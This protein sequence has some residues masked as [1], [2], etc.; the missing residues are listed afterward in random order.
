MG[1]ILV[2][3]SGYSY[4][5][6]V[7]P[8]YTQGTK[9]EEFLSHYGRLFP[10]VELNFSYYRMPTSDQLLAMVE[11]APSLKFSL[12]A[13]GSM[14]HTIDPIQWRS[15]AAE[16]RK[17]ASALQ[18]A[19]ALAA[20][21]LQFPSSFYYQRQQRTYLHQIVQTLGEFPVAVEFRNSQWYNTR[22][23]D[24]LRQRQ[25]AL[26]CTDAPSVQGAP[27][28]MDIVTS[29]F[30]Y[31]RLHGRNAASWW[32]SDA[33]SRYDYL[34]NDQELKAIAQRSEA[35]ASSTETLYIYFNNHRG[36]QA[37]TNALTLQKMLFVK[38]S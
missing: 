33:A 18:Q 27:L 22:T 17:A 12:K 32:G 2:G 24:A 14:T 1:Q 19:G 38:G 35:L 21:L 20:I 8:V 30:S 36:A 5:E 25:V 11:Q 23:I 13:H 34:Y 16:F 4:T 15:Q 10:T 6:W 3:T 31:V 37:V 7:G 28:V 9:S 26:V 29:S